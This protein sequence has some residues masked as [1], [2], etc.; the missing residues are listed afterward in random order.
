[1]IC[2]VI[3]ASPPAGEGAESGDGGSVGPATTVV[4]ELGA[5]L[6]TDVGPAGW[7]AGL[8]VVVESALRLVVVVVVDAVLLVVD[9]ASGFAGLVVSM[10]EVVSRMVGGPGRRWLVG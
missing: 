5:G 10:V 2:G 9:M 7:G 1:M 8:N 3:W 6:V 4:A